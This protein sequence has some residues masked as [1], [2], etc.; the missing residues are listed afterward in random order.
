MKRIAEAALIIAVVGLCL[1][2]PAA[3]QQASAPPA[4]TQYVFP[5][6]G[7][8]PEQQQA[9]QQQQ[10]Y[11]QGVQQL[12]AEFLRARAACLESKSYTVK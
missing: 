5:A 9:A 10:Q 4:T 3:A 2:G 1:P 8:S 11:Q 7:Q 12:Q 6:A